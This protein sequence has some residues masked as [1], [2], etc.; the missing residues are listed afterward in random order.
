MGEMPATCKFKLKEFG[1]VDDGAKGFD[2]S[3]KTSN[4]TQVHQ[5]EITILLQRHLMFLTLQLLAVL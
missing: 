2:V 1:V 4:V 5:E 3:T